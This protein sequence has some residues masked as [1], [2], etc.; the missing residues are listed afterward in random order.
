MAIGRKSRF[1]IE[2]EDSF[3]FDNKT[4]KK[5]ILSFLNNKDEVKLNVL[6]EKLTKKCIKLGKN[7]NEQLTIIERQRF[8]N[9]TKSKG[10]A[11]FLPV[12]LFGLMT[13][14][15]VLTTIFSIFILIKLYNP[16]LYLLQMV[17]I[18][19]VGCTL[20][21]IFECS[22]MPIL[23][24]YCLKKRAFFEAIGYGEQNFSWKDGK[25]I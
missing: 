9:L 5:P 3:L 12:F 23:I 14:D 6:E 2:K 18:S 4:E 22:G 24:F 11:Q 13:L 15:I 16:S 20:I 19:R 7:L 21:S 25:G 8:K 10:F 17:R 1:F